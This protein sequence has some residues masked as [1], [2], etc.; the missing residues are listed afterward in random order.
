MRPSKDKNLLQCALL[1]LLGTVIPFFFNSEFRQLPTLR[2]ARADARVVQVEHGWWFPEEPGPEHGV[3]RANANILTDDEP[4][5]D[6]AMGTY[7]LRAL[8]C[9]I[10]RAEAPTA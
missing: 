5:Y 2:K 10:E 1:G 4:P 8:L 3:F 6:P 7:Q 9:C